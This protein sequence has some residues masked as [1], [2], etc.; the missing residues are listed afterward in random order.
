M[1]FTMKH[2]LTVTLACMAL[3][4]AWRLPLAT[5]DPAAPARVQA[6]EV[7]RQTELSG[8]VRRTHR[9]LQQVRWID[10]LAPLV[11]GTATDGLAV[12]LPLS[13]GEVAAAARVLAA[14]D[15]AGD[16]QMPSAGDA[17]PPPVRNADVDA[18]WGRF[19]DAVRR[20]EDAIRPRHPNMV[21][22]YVYQ[23]VTHGLT[24]G[25]PYDPRERRETYVGT[26][27]GRGYCLQ[28]AAMD[29][30][31]VVP[32]MMA[33][34]GRASDGAIRDGEG[35]IRDGEGAD[36][37]ADGRLLGP[38]RFYA[39]HGLAGPRIQAWLE[40][41]AIE[42]AARPADGAAAL[43]GMPDGQR[44]AFGLR[45]GLV[46]PVAVERCLAGYVE[47]CTRMF[48][49]PGTVERLGTREAIRAANR[50][51]MLDLQGAML[52]MPGAWSPLRDMRGLLSDV[53][54]EF[55]PDAFGRFW[56]SDL[57]VR[58]AFEAAFQV[59]L[60]EW[61]MSWVDRSLGIEPSGPAVPRS[62]AL[63]GLLAIG[64]LAAIATRRHRRSAIG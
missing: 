39:S 28:V 42:L 59:D 4:A 56:T 1:A 30:G 35:A 13:A 48:L 49:A 17:P 10:S 16:A 8:D 45:L 7:I 58:E 6:P 22:G 62:A 27:E 33:E 57:D 31:Q 61:L 46:R 37:R 14:D 55:G 36:E 52:N 25:A 34:V 11:V 15:E 26:H 2:W 24:A 19:H 44:G 63:G 29:V 53:E 20:H 51:G 43:A 5:R 21:V 32:A 64:L 23:P 12:T 40:A 9:V 18:L 38:C 50:P 3:V 54:A 41:G 47:A 60:T